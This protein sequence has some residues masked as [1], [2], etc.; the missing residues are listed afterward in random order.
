PTRRSSD[1]GRPGRVHAH[2]GPC[3]GQQGK[4]SVQAPR[5]RPSAGPPAGGAGPKGGRN[6]MMK[7]YRLEDL[8][9]GQVLNRDLRAEQDVE[10][11]VDAIIADVRA[12]GDAALRDY[13]R[14]FDGAELAALQVSSSSPSNSRA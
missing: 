11:V 9:P 4:L 3:G 12:R 10:A 2:L 14:K 13:A 8:T 5:G 7:L 6:V 1:L